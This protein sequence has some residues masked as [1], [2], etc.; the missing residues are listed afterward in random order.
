MIPSII[1]ILLVNLDSF[2]VGQM[3]YQRLWETIMPG[4]DPADEKFTSAASIREDNCQELYLPLSPLPSLAFEHLVCCSSSLLAWSIETMLF[5]LDCHFGWDSPDE[6]LKYPV[7]DEAQI[8]SKK[9]C[10][11]S[12]LAWSIKM[13]L[14]KPFG[15]VYQNEYPRKDAL[16]AFWLGVSKGC[17]CLEKYL[18]IG[19]ATDTV[20]S[21]SLAGG[22][23]IHPQYVTN[24]D[25][26]VIRMRPAQHP[27]Q[28][29]ATYTPLPQVKLNQPKSA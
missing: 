27:L 18:F 8:V 7:I 26:E 1:S 5:G 24:K 13:T 17:F 4:P 10:S 12:L 6:A 2:H 11:S 16:R 15:L 14:F 20:P 23:T 21:S 3:T 9:G 19:S 29:P 22:E 28:V 25:F